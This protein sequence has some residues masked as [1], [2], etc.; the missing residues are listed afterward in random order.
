MLLTCAAKHFCVARHIPVTRM[1]KC[2][3]CNQYL[4]TFCVG[5]GFIPPNFEATDGKEFDCA[6]C[7]GGVLLQMIPA[8][9]APEANHIEFSEKG[10]LN[11]C[12]S[13]V[14]DIYFYFLSVADI[15]TTTLQMRRSC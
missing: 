7:T 2:R 14:A 4:H 5:Q 15:P 6:Y 3:K 10:V 13:Y 1:H 8:P 9:A 12:C 11:Q